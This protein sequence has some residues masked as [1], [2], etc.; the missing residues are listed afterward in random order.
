MAETGPE[1][2]QFVVFEGVDG[3][4]K[5]TFT[6]ALAQYYR[7]LAPDTPV[8]AASFPGSDPGTLGELVYEFHHG[9][10]EGAL[11]PNNVAL[12][13]LQLLHVAAHVDAI[14]RMIAPAFATGHAVIL[15]R[16]WWS[17]YAYVRRAVP[18]EAAWHLVSAEVPFWQGLPAPTV[19]YLH[20]SVSL[21]PQELGSATHSQISTY[22]Q[23]VAEAQ[24]EQG[25]R[26]HTIRNDAEIEHAWEHILTAL[27]LPQHPLATVTEFNDHPQ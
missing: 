19:I 5:T 22:Y 9:R 18:P 8:L 13:A 3:T 1:I 11:A 23:E 7:F 15:D 4:G 14:V 10:L 6:H 12:P 25:I 20:R 17:T 2:P 16:Y 24:R 26:V 27:N 21:K